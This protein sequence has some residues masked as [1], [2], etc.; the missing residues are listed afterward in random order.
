MTDATVRVIARVGIP[1]DAVRVRLEN[2]FGETQ[3]EISRARVA[4]RRRGAILI[5]ATTR[6][7]TFGGQSSVTIPAGGGIVSHSVPLTISGWQDVAV[8][9]HV[10]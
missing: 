2:T 6:V 7:L 10:A 3:V 8:S 4:L 9:L 5:P 1:G